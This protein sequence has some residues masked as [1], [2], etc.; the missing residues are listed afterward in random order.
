MF[1]VCGCFSLDSGGGIS[2]EVVEDEDTG[3]GTGAFAGLH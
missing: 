3:E 2:T 1:S